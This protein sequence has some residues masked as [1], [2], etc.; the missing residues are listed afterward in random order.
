M[1]GVRPEAPSAVPS[2]SLGVRLMPAR[3]PRLLQDDLAASVGARRSRVP[4]TVLVPRELEIVEC[5][6]AVVAADALQLHRVG[7]HVIVV[8]VDLFAVDRMHG[9]DHDMRVRDAVVDMRLDHPLVSAVALPHPI[10]CQR[11]HRLGIQV[12]LGVGRDHEVVVLAPRVLFE[13]LADR[14]HLHIPIGAI[15]INRARAKRHGAAVARKIVLDLLAA[16]ELP[17]E[18]LEHRHASA[19]PPIASLA[20]P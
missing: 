7:L 14:V 4:G 18:R 9:V 8:E 3:R 1:H 15:E 10:V 19:R 6:V 16:A 12:V 13:H 20:A 2:A 11:V 5:A 17:G